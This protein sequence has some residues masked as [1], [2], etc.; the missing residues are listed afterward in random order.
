MN[1]HDVTIGIIGATGAVGSVALELLE[2]QGHPPE[3]IVPIASPRSEGK[4][5][6]YFSQ[7]LIVR[8]IEKELLDNLDAIIISATSQISEKWAPIAVKSGVVVID[9]GSVFR[10]NSSVP[11]VVPEVNGQDVEWHTGI[12]STPNCTTTPLVMVL[13]ALRKLSSIKRVNVSTYQ[14]VSGTGSRARTELINQTR[15]MIFDQDYRIDV[16]PKP[17]GFNIFPHVDDFLEN[18]YTKEEMKMVNESRKILHDDQIRISVTCVRVP[19]H[20]SHSE[21]LQIEFTDNVNLKEAIKLLSDYSGITVMDDTENDIYP[22][23]LDSAGQDD[24][25]VG[26]IRKDIAIDNAISL[27]L[28][29]DNLRKGASLNA[30]QILEELIKR[31]RMGLNEL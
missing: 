21:S 8:K 9:D 20:I 4:K 29:C 13:D 19:V 11:L 18:G 23:P 25:F 1:F 31:D 10:M 17:I 5:L 24:V 30:I 27:W 15:S 26:R 28:S 16:Y 7:D 3:K 14:A 2:N 22:T 6:K 12:I